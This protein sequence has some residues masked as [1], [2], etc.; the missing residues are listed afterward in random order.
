MIAST[1]GKAIRMGRV[2]GSV[3]TAL[4]W[5]FCWFKANR[6][7]MVVECQGGEYVQKT[8]AINKA[9]KRKNRLNRQFFI[10]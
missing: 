2:F 8:G 5:R 3:L 9:K 1:T 7:L 6:S 4:V 10:Q